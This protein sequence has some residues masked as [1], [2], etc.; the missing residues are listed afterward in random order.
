[1]QFDH[2]KRRDFI[3]LLGGSQRGRWSRAPK[4]CRANYQRLDC[5]ARRYLPLT[6]HRS[7][8]WFHRRCAQVA[9]ICARKW[10]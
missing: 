3:A 4:T 2:L 5:L 7:L 1:M 6:V 9:D 10:V 8:H